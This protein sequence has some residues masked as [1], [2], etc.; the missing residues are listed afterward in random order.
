MSNLLSKEQINQFIKDNDIRSAKDIQTALKK[1]FGETLQAMLEAEMDEHLGYT[2]HDDK[3]KS[4]TNRRNGRGTKTVRSDYGEMEIN[5]PRDRES[6]FE[7]VIVGKRQ[8]DVTGIEEQ[9]IAL[10]ARGLSTRDIEEHLRELYG[11]GVSATFIS[12]VTD[13]IL[14]LVR[15]WQSRPLAPVYAAVFLDAIHYKV[16]HEGSVVSKASY[17]AIGIDLDGQKDVL[18]MWIGASE[19]A[20][21][22]LSVL[23]DIKSRGTLDILIAC[24][25]NLNGFSEAIEAVYPKTDVQKCIVHQV[26]NSIKYVSYKDVKT[27]TSD[28]RA[29][30]TSATE[31]AANG[32]LDE[33]EQTWGMK[34]P[35]I[36]RSWRQNWAELSTF[37]RYPLEIRKIIYTTNVIEGYHRQL[38]KVTKGKSIFPSDESLTKMLYL[39]TQNVMKKW[40]MR[41][42]Y[43]GQILHQLSILYP[44]RVNP[45]IG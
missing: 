37:F 15:E 4:T 2:R 10:Y 22:W 19:S 30:Y 5:V 7:P 6:S 32:A 9:I 33:F 34:Y 39:I 28:L 43:W 45:Y 38:R 16:R 42:A 41:I 24:T 40:T 44:E 26:R 11:I 1:V 31:E 3:S 20:K 14:P 21:F 29:V 13:K 25:D 35:L 18:G 27:V 8:R 23:N 12:D 36:V 17:M